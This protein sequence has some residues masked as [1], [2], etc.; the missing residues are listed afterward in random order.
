MPLYSK[1]RAKLPW[2]L[3]LQKLLI[4]PSRT[5]GAG[6]TQ[7]APGATLFSTTRDSAPFTP[8]LSARSRAQGWAAFVGKWRK[9]SADDAYPRSLHAHRQARYHR[10]GAATAVRRDQRTERADAPP[11]GVM[12][13][14]RALVVFV[15]TIGLAACAGHPLRLTA[16][17][18]ASLRG[19]QLTTTAR[20]PTPFFVRKPGVIY[21]GIG[22]LGY[23]LDL[24]ARIMREDD[25]A[26]PTPRM[27]QQLRDDLQH[28]Y[29]LKVAPRPLYVS[30]DD[31]TQ[32]TAAYPEGDLLL[33]VWTGNLSLGPIGNDQSKY[34]LEYTVYFRLIDA[35]IIHLID[36]KKG[37]VIA[38]GTC[39]LPSKARQSAPTYDEMLA[40]GARQLKH[41]LDLGAQACVDQFRAT[42]LTVE[43]AP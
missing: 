1:Q 13:P 23:G 38:S 35:K 36:G 31:V 17:T 14:L 33:D 3:F 20:R 42:V 24:G 27:M 30:D 26:D 39:S 19:R 43:G 4:C 28:R 37:L 8:L 21:V 5:R 29:D 2:P 16:A 41:E 11:W 15:S 40:D 12:H 10:V 34:R 7:C 25:I 9:A 22:T 18:A 32:I 6:F